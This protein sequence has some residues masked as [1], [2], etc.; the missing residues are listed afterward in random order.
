MRIIRSR[1]PLVAVASMLIATVV[2]Q[3][4]TGCTSSQTQAAASDA[5]S[6]KG[7]GSATPARTTGAVA[8][9]TAFVGTWSVHGATMTIS[10]T[11]SVEI[12]SHSGCATMTSP[13]WCDEID[14]GTG[15]PSPDGSA[16]TVTILSSYVR[17]LDTN[18]IQPGATVYK[19][20]GDRF[21][22]RFVEPQLLITEYLIVGGK[23]PTSQSGLGNLYWCG[24]NRDDSDWKCGA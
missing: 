10:S 4:L 5:P 12:E 13:D 8:G 18:E 19:V 14:K 24:P 20:P 22:L 2:S 21:T 3:V 9:V 11:S 16:L 7:Q 23:T 6:V 1:P 15:A 17:D